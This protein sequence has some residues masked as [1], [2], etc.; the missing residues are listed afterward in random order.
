MIVD[1]TACMFSAL[2]GSS[3]SGAFIES[4]AGIREGCA[5]RSRLGFD[6]S[7]VCCFDLLY[8]TAGAVAA[9]QIRLLP[10]IDGS[11]I[12]DASVDKENRHGRSNRVNSGF[13]HNRHDGIFLQHRQ[14]LNRGLSSLC[15]FE[16]GNRS[17]QRTQLRFH[18]TCCDVH[19]L[20]R[21]RY[22]ALNQSATFKLGSLNKEAGKAIEWIC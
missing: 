4:A 9:T 11:R 22:S 1:A 2:V 7:P 20:F 16:G 13:R 15:D 5:H 8:T 10:G 17:R 14:W 19:T 12:D 18:R 21:F 6:C 3:T